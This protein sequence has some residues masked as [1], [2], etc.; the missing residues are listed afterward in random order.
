MR[1]HKGL[2]LVVLLFIAL[3][4][5]GC[6]ISQIRIGWVGTQ[7]TDHIACKY[8]RFKG[9]DKT[10]IHA[11]GGQTLSLSFDAEVQEGSLVLRVIDPDEA[12]LWD[13]T[14]SSD[15]ADTARIPLEREGYYEIAIVGQD[16][17]GNFDV[18]WEIR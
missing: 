3:I 7:S 8:E 17:K 14:L 5:E 16:T 6:S 12:V 4:V 11:Q 2:F 9:I 1:N 13:T 10:A 15:D 18:S